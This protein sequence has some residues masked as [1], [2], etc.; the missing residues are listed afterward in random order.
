MTLSFWRYAHLV[1]AI[2]SSLFLVLAAVTG[3]ILAVDAIQEKIPSYQV[4]TFDKITLSETLPVLRK[5]YPEI[6]AVSVDHNQFVLLEGIDQEGND[7]NAYVDPTNGKI[8][9]KPTPKSEFIQW[10]TALHR[11]L[12]LK[13]TGRFIVGFISFLLAL[14]ALS[15]LALIIN[16]QRS[17]RS[18]FSKIVKENFAQ[19]YHIIT[20]RLALLP[21]LII[22]LT[23][24]YLTLEKFH[25]FIENDASTT[26]T[27]AQPSSKKQKTSFF[28]TTLLADV[29]K[30]EFPFSDDPEEY[31]IIHLKDKEIEVHQITGAVV[32]EKPTATTTQL[33]DL[34][35]DLHTGRTSILWAVIL[36]LASIN[37]FFFIYSGFA[38]TLR[39]RASRIKNKFKAKDS[40]IILL[41][42]SENGSTLRFA[43]AVQQQ[44][45]ALGKKAYLAEMNSYTQFPKAKQLLVFAATHGMGDA[46]SNANQFI[47]LLSKRE[48]KQK[49]KTAI[50]GFGSKSYADFCGFAYDVEAALAKQNWSETI[51]PLHTINDKSTEEFMAWI[52]LW[53]SAT[54]LPLATTPSLYNAIPKGLQTFEVVAKTQV[55]TDEDTFLVSF[56]TP[57]TTKF[58]SGD[59]LAIYP[60]NDSRERLYSIGKH[61]GKLQLVVKLHEYGLGSG[62][63]NQLE[64]GAK[65][66]ARVITNTAFHFP[67]QATK[68]ALI[69]NGTGIAPFLGMIQEST[70]KT[71]THLYCG[72]RTE[73]KSVAS[74][75]KLA[76][77]MMDQQR[78]QSFNLA[79]SRIP[80]GCRVTDLIER[81]AAFFK[82]LLN[83][84]GVIMICGSLAMQ[85]DVE[86]VL[87]TLLEE[88]NISVSD[89][90]AKGQILTDCY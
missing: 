31:F 41:V 65:I 70:P 48:Q 1:L 7:V 15:G 20:G 73:T 63:L 43:N 27:V 49:I 17:I 18:V 81:D 14:I 35:L 51:V 61:D 29:T 21:I 52:Q 58:Q 36:G 79:L 3:T 2:F 42:G 68:V 10:T 24:A 13:E 12:F 33:K 59:L 46:P 74:Y 83:E 11:S 78:L 69:S 28:N 66:K 75:T 88:S 22:A 32:T 89:Y 77:E 55:S 90:K 57:W 37:L 56:K 54:S 71:E 47:E 53:N 23:G 50:I 5:T 87:E 34:S 45:I 6:T 4:S 60:A 72:F 82:A 62:Y 85:K 9:G 64:I 25:F 76:Q 38:M 80:N 84:N 86:K 19:Y 30:I 67:K 16:R 26:E 44:F 39:R 40:E 8:L